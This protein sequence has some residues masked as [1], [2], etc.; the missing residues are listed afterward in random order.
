MVYVYVTQFFAPANGAKRP[1]DFIVIKFF[2]LGLLISNAIESIL[3]IPKILDVMDSTKMQ[4][5]ELNDVNIKKQELKELVEEKDREQKALA[6]EQ[7]REVKVA[8]TEMSRAV[9]EILESAA[10]QE[11]E[12]E[13]KQEAEHSSSKSH[14]HKGKPSHSGG[15]HGEG[16]HEESSA[17]HGEHK[18]GEHHGKKGSHHKSGHH[19]KHSV[20]IRKRPRM[21]LTSTNYVAVFMLFYG[22][23]TLCLGSYSNPSAAGLATHV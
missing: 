7:I 22:S 21:T 18:S 5:K 16:D 12:F 19:D 14:H 10:K 8:V 23:T 1:S 2:L 11:D 20:T 13:L 6:K 17:A 4:A 3:I 15:V 9:D